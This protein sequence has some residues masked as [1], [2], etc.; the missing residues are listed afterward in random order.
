MFRFG[1]FFLIIFVYSAVQYFCFHLNKDA[2]T[3]LHIYIYNNIRMQNAA[4]LTMVSEDRL[5]FP[6]FRKCVT[7]H[8]A[9]DNNNGCQETLTGPGTTHGTNKTIF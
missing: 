4:W 7:T 3:A 8:S 1:C 2:I 9:I 6:Y 5:R